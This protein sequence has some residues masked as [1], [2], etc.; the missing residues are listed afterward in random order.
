MPASPQNEARQLNAPMSPPPLVCPKSNCTVQFHRRQERD[1]HLRSHF[2][3]W[4]FC[5]FPRCPWRGSRQDVFKVHW[6]RNHAKHG[7]APVRRQNVIYNPDPLVKLVHWNAL[8]VESASDISHS[9]VGIRA[10]ELNKLGVWEGVW[11][12]RAKFGQ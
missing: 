3:H 1:R 8:T 11:G 10:K 5:P 12:R 9:I 7:Q 4:M 6:K 2:S